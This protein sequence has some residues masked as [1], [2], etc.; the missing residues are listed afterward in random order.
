MSECKH[1]NCTRKAS[2]ID[3]E[4]CCGICHVDDLE[5]QLKTKDEE[6]ESF[7]AN[8]T[9]LKKHVDEKP[10]ETNVGTWLKMKT[11]ENK[12]D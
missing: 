12:S 6:I 2:G 4:Y 1:E 9:E 11:M 3:S 5:K 7:T 8:W 10:L